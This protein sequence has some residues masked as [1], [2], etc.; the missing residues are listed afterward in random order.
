[1][2]DDTETDVPGAELAEPKVLHV[3]AESGN[4]ERVFDVMDAL[5]QG[6]GVE[7]YYEHVFHDKATMR[8]TVRPEMVELL[9]W[10]ATEEPVTIQDV[11][12]EF[13]GDDRD[14]DQEI[15]QL[16]AHGLCELDDEEGCRP[17]VRYD[18]IVVHHSLRSE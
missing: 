10:I 12:D 18:E 2:I 14:V 5:D 9:E 13:G 7:P 11:V 6:D 1:M 17:R 15:D 4:T 3:Y 16:V 8:E